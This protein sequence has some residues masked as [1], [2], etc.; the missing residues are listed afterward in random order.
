MLMKKDEGVEDGCKDNKQ[1]LLFGSFDFQFYGRCGLAAKPAGMSVSPA[2][3]EYICNARNMCIG[4]TSMASP[5]FSKTLAKR[6]TLF[7]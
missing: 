3:S 1:G 7:K 6:P 2:T 5:S 4:S